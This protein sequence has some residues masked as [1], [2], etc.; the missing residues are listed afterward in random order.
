MKISITLLEGRV[1]E[2]ELTELGNGYSVGF[3]EGDGPFP[4][5][6]NL[7]GPQVSFKSFETPEKLCRAIRATELDRATKT[8]VIRLLQKNFL[9]A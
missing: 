6:Y 7:Y 4:R 8:A 1:T 3:F 2:A 5:Q 9:V